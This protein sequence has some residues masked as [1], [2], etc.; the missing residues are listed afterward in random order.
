MAGGNASNGRASQCRN[1][2]HVF[3]GEVNFCPD[4][5][6]A[7]R[8]ALA[9]H[10]RVCGSEFDPDDRFCSDCGAVRNPDA[11]DVDASG[12]APSG[13]SEPES[14][15]DSEEEMAEFRRRVQSYLAEGWEL[16]HDYGD[17]AVLVDR[18]LGSLPAHVLLFMFTGG[19]GNALYGFHR[20]KNC[21]ERLQ[22]SAGEERRGGASSSPAHPSNQVTA[23]ESTNTTRVVIGV[24]LALA[25]LSVLLSLPL[26]VVGW[27]IGLPLLVGGLY[28][29]PPVRRRIDRRHSI[30]RFG[31]VRSTDETVVRAPDRPCVAC[32]RPIDTGVKRTYREETVLAGIPLFTV[33][34]GENHYCESCSV[35][36]T[37]AEEASDDGPVEPTA[38]TGATERESN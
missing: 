2:G 12:T 6:S 15:P 11:E 9:A 34:D 22:L 24:F 5:G 27:V 29:F 10:C 7:I 25:G 1:C 18:D 4:C 32:G 3:R 30:T 33:R 8:D 37:E 19:I 31:T 17:S 26:D 21:A 13:S 28:L 23:S 14:A 35:R 20:Y 16:E 36:A 38:S